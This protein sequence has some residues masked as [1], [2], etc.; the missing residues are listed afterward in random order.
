[1]IIEVN[2]EINLIQVSHFRFPSGELTW[3]SSSVSKR[4][5]LLSPADNVCFWRN[6]DV[7]PYTPSTQETRALMPVLWS[8]LETQKERMG[9]LTWVMAIVGLLAAA[10]DGIMFHLQPNTQ[11]CLREEI[12]KDVLVSGEYEIQETP[13]QKV[14]IQVIVFC[15]HRCFV[16]GSRWNRLFGFRGCFYQLF[17]LFDK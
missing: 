15:V 6:S 1:M 11:K 10:A 17:S 13:G 8:P 5:R 16:W 4:H 2:K 9:R 14:D 7:E 12:H 3:N